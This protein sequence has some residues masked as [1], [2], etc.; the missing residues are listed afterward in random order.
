[1]K[2]T[3]KNGWELGLKGDSQRPPVGG[4]GVGSPPSRGAPQ[5]RRG[6]GG[7]PEG[8]VGLG[9]SPLACRL[10]ATLLKILASHPPSFPISEGKHVPNSLEVVLSSGRPLHSPVRLQENQGCSGHI[11]ATQVR[12]DGGKTWGSGGFSA[13]R[14]CPG[15][16]R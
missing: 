7:G 16:P 1:M 6:A 2:T 10:L 8:S 3:P 5:S 15:E 11:Q 12:I 13:A 4:G 9:I 14:R